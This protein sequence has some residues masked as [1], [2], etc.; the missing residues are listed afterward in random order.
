MAKSKS[1][2][3][4]IIFSMGG[5]IV[6]P[7]EIDV[8]FLKTIKKFIL[9]LLSRGYRLVIIIGGGE[10]SKK[11]NQAAKALSKISNIDLDWMGIACTK[12][13][14]EL[15]RVILS[16]YAYPQVVADQNKIKN[17]GK[18]K[19]ILASGLKPGQS[20]DGQAVGW[21]K[22]L[23]AKEII[24]L[25]NIDKAYTADPRKDKTARPLDR[26]SWEQYRKIVGNKWSPRMSTPFDPT[27][28]RLAQKYGMRVAVLNGR[29]LNNLKNYLAGKN[30]IGTVIE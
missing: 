11:Y 15:V 18:Y 19:L 20:T 6:V 26:V 17:V 13:N 5:S 3:K 2:N 29:K 14:A 28:S 23:G 7:D 30:F 10:L 22:K 16:K 8:K 9:S 25:T 27:A 1:V 4:T 21:A 12:V 24:N